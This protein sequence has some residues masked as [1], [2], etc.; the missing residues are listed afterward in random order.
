MKSVQPSDRFFSC[1]TGRDSKVGPT[2]ILRFGR[3][4]ERLWHGPDRVRFP[5]LVFKYCTSTLAV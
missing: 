4:N 3:F 2:Y 5:T 1:R